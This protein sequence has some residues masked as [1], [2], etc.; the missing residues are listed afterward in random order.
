MVAL[1]LVEG[2]APQ[3]G[4]EYTRY[5]GDSGGIAGRRDDLQCLRMN[6]GYSAD[7]WTSRLRLTVADWTGTCMKDVWRSTSTT[8]DRVR[9]DTS[10]S[11]LVADSQYTRAEEPAT[12]RGWPLEGEHAR[13]TSTQ[14]VLQTAVDV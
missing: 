6:K 14:L 1:A 5:S 13:T 9:M 4:E 8:R 12:M 7:M 10:P 11:V 2:T 3:Q